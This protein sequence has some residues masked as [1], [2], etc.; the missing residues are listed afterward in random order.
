MIECGASGGGALLPP[1]AG[2]AGALSG[3]SQRLRIRAAV[4]GRR[5][6]SLQAGAGRGPDPDR[7][8]H[9][10][11]ASPAVANGLNVSMV[12][13]AALCGLLLQPPMAKVAV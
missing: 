13:C 3:A 4:V 8:A 6:A 10:E 2:A 9:R 1:K 7:G 5:A 11:C 12:L